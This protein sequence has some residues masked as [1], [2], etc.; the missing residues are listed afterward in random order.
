MMVTTDKRSLYE[1]WLVRRERLAHDTEGIQQYR[2]IQLQ[3]LDYLIERYRDAP[4]VQ[5]PARFPLKTEVVL[6]ERAMVVHNHL[7]RGQTS[8]TKSTLEVKHRMS[9]IVERMHHAADQHEAESDAGF[10]LAPDDA[11]QGSTFSPVGSPPRSVLRN[12]LAWL[13][14]ELPSML[15]ARRRVTEAR[16]RRLFRRFANPKC[17]DV[18]LLFQLLACDHPDVPRYAFQAWLDRMRAGCNDDISRHLRRNVGALDERELDSL[19]ALLAH[20]SSDER[21]V[22][23]EMLATHGTLD[24]VSL[25]CDLL[26]LPVQPDEHPRERT[27]LAAVVQR[28]VDRQS[29][30]AA[31]RLTP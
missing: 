10:D 21:V 15:R 12:A 3:L 5:Q 11:T 31:G 13:R 14:W 30:V 16:F 23:M 27:T 9:A 4:E 26:N 29:T 18:W 17:H 2:R 24:D 19:R 1:D 7:W 28:I 8:G 20:A 25:L 22:A 6:N